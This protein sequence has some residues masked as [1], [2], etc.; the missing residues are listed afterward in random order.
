[1][2]K[3]KKQQNK[4]FANLDLSYKLYSLYQVDPKNPPLSK[5]DFEAWVTIF[6][7]TNHEKFKRYWANYHTERAYVTGM[8]SDEELESGEEFRRQL[9]KI[10]NLKL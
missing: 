6:G 7:V 4:D 3:H 5:S 9:E 8:I 10:E 2:E 1:M